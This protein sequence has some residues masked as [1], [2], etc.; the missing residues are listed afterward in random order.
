MGAVVIER[1]GFETFVEPHLHAMW[2][3]ASRLAG[4]DAR[5]DVY[6]QA[7]ETAWRRFSTYDPERG[8]PR[9]WLLLLVADRARK[10][11]RAARPT[12]E[13][14]DRA[15]P[16]VDVDRRLDISRAVARL[17]RRQ[18]LAVELHY[19][20]GLPV[21]ECAQ[22]MGCAVGTVTSTLSDARAHLR[23]QLEVTS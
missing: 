16:E 17:P 14:L 5:D 18:R 7:L 20:L 15:D 1:V 2:T 6:Q 3:L 13:L 12:L 4:P 21:A 11:R 10:T 19:V 8:M 22:V 23:R 9:T